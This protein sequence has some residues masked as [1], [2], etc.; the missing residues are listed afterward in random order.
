MPA[1]VLS[2]AWPAIVDGKGP[3][4]LESLGLKGAGVKDTVAWGRLGRRVA[5]VVGVLVFALA[6]SASPALARGKPGDP[7]PIPGGLS[8]NFEPV[9]ADPFVHVLPPF[10]PFEMS[11]IGDFS[12]TVGASEIQG[13]ARGS[14]G[15]TYTFDTDMRFMVGTYVDTAGNVQHGSFAFI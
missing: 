1:C 15:T 5:A 8:A 2:A 4:A 12:G 13:T 10:P 11:T 3:E 7:K 6:I 14:D 9:P